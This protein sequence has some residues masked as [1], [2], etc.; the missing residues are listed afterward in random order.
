MKK[1]IIGSILLGTIVLSACSSPSMTDSSTSEF[2]ESSLDTAKESTEDSGKSTEELSASDNSASDDR[3][4]SNDSSDESLTEASNK[5]SNKASNESSSD[6]PEEDSNTTDDAKETKRAAAKE[7]SSRD[8]DRLM[9]K[10]A[11]EAGASGDDS[12]TYLIADYDGDGS[13]E[14]FVYVGEDAD[15]YSECYGTVYYVDDDE[16]DVVKNGY[17]SG[18]DVRD[19]FKEYTVED[20]VFI[21]LEESYTTSVNSLIYYIEDGTYK[22]SCISGLGY[23]YENTDID[24]YC[25]IYNVYDYFYD[26]EAGH[27]SEGVFTGHTYKDY[28]FYYDQKSGD[29]KEYVGTL[30]SEKDLAKA[31]GFD[32][33][34]QIKSEGYEIGDIYKRDNGIINVNYSKTTQNDDGSGTIEYHNATFDENTQKFVPYEGSDETWQESDSGGTYDDSITKYRQ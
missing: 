10:A 23:F 11:L 15:E 22:E 31:C 13:A 14:G 18:A 20:R 5:A 12:I 24:G 19:I 2:T 6:M 25:I 27:E 26:Y 7:A 8:K 21:C 9:N 33:A 28:Y 4:A 32:L 16:C 34:A 3:D 1:R 17:F 29:F 30:I